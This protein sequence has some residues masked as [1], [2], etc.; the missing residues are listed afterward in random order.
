[1][2]SIIENNLLRVTIN[3]F[4]AE[5]QSIYRKDKDTEYQWQG[6]PT[7]WS[8][9]APNLF[10]ICGRLVEGKYTYDGATYEMDIHGFAKDMEWEV[11]HQTPDSLTLQ[12]QSTPRTLIAY[13]WAFSLEMVYTL[14]DN[15]LSVTNILHKKKALA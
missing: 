11:I 4:G 6:D 3:S 2:I 5:L 7:F 13:P 12:L 8:D 1:M 9:R 14:T 15:T 10:P